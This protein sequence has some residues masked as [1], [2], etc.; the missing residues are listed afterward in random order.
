[1]SVRDDVRARLSGPGGLFELVEEDVLGQRLL[2]YKNRQP[3]LREVLAGSGLRGETEYIVDRDRRLTYAGLQGSVASVAAALREQYGV[4]KGDRVAILAANCAEWAIAFWATVSLGG[5]V[6]ALN[7]WWT[8]D[9]IE[10]G[11]SDSDPKLLIGD[12][13]RL[14]RAE[15][16][17]LGVPIVEMESAF[18]ELERFAPGAALPDVEIDED[19][20]AVILYT[21]GT[22]GRPKGAVA[23]HRSIIGFVQGANANGLAGAMIEREERG[24]ELPLGAP[25]PQMV[26]LATSPMFHLSGL[27]A[28]IVLQL[29]GGGK[30]V[31]HP[32]R[33]DPESVLQ[34]M[35]DE[36][37]TQFTAMGGM[38]PRIA[39]HPRLLDFDLDRVTSVG[40]GGAPASPAVQDL[41]RKAFP[42]AS[43]NVGIGY[44]SSE[45]I[46]VPATFGGADYKANPESTGR[47]TFGHEVQIRDPD[48]KVLPRGRE[49]EIFVRSAWNMLEYW[50]KPEATAETIGPDRWLATGDIGRIEEGDLLYINS[51][52]RD[53]I[54][55]NAENVYPVEIEYRLDK[56]P[57]VRESAVYGIEH[58]EWGQEVKAVVVPEAGSTPD[59]EALGAWVGETLS[60]YK[61]PTTWEIRADPLP[62]N[63]SGKVLKNVLMGEAENA[64]VEE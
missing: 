41:M 42:N 49:G 5:V 25:R 54:L 62:R 15:G 35:Q 27:Y 10:Y 19:D 63:P 38:G 45:T 47:I 22:T 37:V 2:V 40:F 36:G 51:R 3:S 16:I 24:E 58:E 17:D 14:A 59:A 34:L 43:A 23:T 33:F 29:A 11:V 60:A 21:S 55:R 20:R 13:K 4:E 7:G 18:A 64:F 56:H 32:G 57:D 26:V 46:S 31:V 6:A 48:A 30:L 12:R 50:R 1:M 28:Q 61:V 39:H 9:E 53:M 52:A 44:G 8:S